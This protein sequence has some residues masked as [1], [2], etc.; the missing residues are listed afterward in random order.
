MLLDWIYIYIYIYIRDKKL[1]FIIRR[2]ED[3][4]IRDVIKY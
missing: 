2:L 3:K 4:I 1:L